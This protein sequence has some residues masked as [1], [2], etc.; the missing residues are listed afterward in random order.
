MLKLWDFRCTSCDFDWE[1][2]VDDEKSV[3]EK[4]GAEV[5]RSVL[6]VGKLGHWSIQDADGRRQELLRRSAKHTLSE[7]RKNP[8]KFGAE[9][10]ARARE[11]QIR[12]FGGIS[13]K[14]THG[15]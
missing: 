10:V 7:L 8:E 9:G 3:C 12:S 11:G 2:L 15:S 5:T 1:D 14:P 6:C 13:R 4:C